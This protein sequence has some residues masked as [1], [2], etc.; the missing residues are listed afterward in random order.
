VELKRLQ[1]R[2]FGTLLLGAAIW[3]IGCAPA[4][5]PDPIR[6]YSEAC[7]PSDALSER[8]VEYAQEL[9]TEADVEASGTRR[10]YHLPKLPASS[11]RLA[12]DTTKCRRAAHTFALAAGDSLHPGN[13][14][15][16]H[17]IEIGNRF[18]VV[19]PRYPIQAGEY[20]IVLVLDERFTQL[21]GFTY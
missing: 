2:C 17:L 14:R 1:Q 7:A 15:S 10:E 9:V 21:L 16:V 20:G 8:L 11:V 3:I 4:A 18:W 5:S 6:P 19:D 13:D 12:T